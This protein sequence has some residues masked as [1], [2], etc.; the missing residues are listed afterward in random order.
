L[1][2]TKVPRFLTDLKLLS[3]EDGQ[4]GLDILP[5]LA[6][7]DERLDGSD[8][9]VLLGAHLASAVALAQG[10]GAVLEGLEVDGDAEGGA[11]LVVA[12]VP[13]ADRSGRVVDAAG[14]T[15]GPELLRQL[16]RMGSEVLVGGQGNEEHLGRSNSG[17]EGEDLRLVRNC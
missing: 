15:G 4:L 9:L 13:L 12:A 3:F 17:R 8:D 1:F 10:D 2:L 14:N 7:V 11:E 16:A 6:A 5:G